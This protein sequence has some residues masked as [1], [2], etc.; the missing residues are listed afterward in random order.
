MLLLKKGAFDILDNGKSPPVGFKHA[1]GH[2]IFDVR[3]TLERKAR[4]VKDQVRT[5]DYVARTLHIRRGGVKRKCSHLFDQ[6]SS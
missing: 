2:L 4:W 3:M 5:Q 6:R 1:T